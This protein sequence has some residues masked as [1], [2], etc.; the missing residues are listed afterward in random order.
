MNPVD[1]AVLETLNIADIDFGNRVREDYNNMKELAQSIKDNGLIHPIAVLNKNELDDRDQLDGIEKDSNKP[2]LL[3]AG[4][5]RITAKVLLKHDTV[6]CRIYDHHL[7]NDEIKNIEL[8]ENLHRENLTWQEEI[9][10]KAEIHE[11]QASLYGTKTARGTRGYTMDDTAETLGES[12]SNLSLDLKLKKAMD[13]MPELK[14]AKT[15][16]DA[17]KMLKK[18][19]R[20]VDNKKQVEKISKSKSSKPEDK[21]KKDLADSYILGDFFEKVERIKSNS[22]DLIE[23]DPP[24]GIDLEKAKKGNADYTESYNEVHSKEYE[25]FI[26]KTLGECKRVLKP[27]GWLVMWFAPEPWYEMFLNTLRTHDYKFKN[28]PGIWVKGHGQTMRPELYLANSYEMFLYARKNNGVINKGGTANTFQYKPVSPNN[29]IHPTE[30][31]VEM[32]QDVLNTFIKPGGRVL[33][34]FAGSGNSLLAA[35]N[36]GCSAVGYDLSEEYRNE[37]VLRVHNGEFGN[38]SSYE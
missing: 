27:N 38:Y 10:L 31:P 20:D 18:L 12:R 29:K 30:R 32:I 28:I 25:H 37:Y 11:F 2:Y 21:L 14:E 3:L 4:G 5:R 36:I 15:K 23:L 6:A 7:S 33:V 26:M 8:I 22:I 16:S 34:P 9:D 13:S 1:N 35:A 17:R 24:Y 19:K